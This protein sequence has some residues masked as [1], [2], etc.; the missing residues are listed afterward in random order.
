MSCCIKSA[1]YL[2]VEQLCFEV[3]NNTMGRTW[4]WRPKKQQVDC[5]FKKLLKMFM[6]KDNI[7]Y[8][9]A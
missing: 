7:L 3:L 6:K 9:I 1:D 8:S 5:Y 4:N 2:S